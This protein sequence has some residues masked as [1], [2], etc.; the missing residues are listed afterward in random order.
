M[1][2]IV[3]ILIGLGVSVSALYGQKA[4]KTSVFLMGENEKNYESLKESYRHSLLE[5]C[6][7][8]MKK[9]FENW[10]NFVT[11]LEDYA[12]QEGVDINGVKL[13]LHTFFSPEG[14]VDHIGFLLKPTSKNVDLKELK[15]LL[16][17]FAKN[18]T[19]PIKYDHKF[20]HYT[21][22]TFPTFSQPSNRD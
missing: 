5:V 21:G 16:K 12:K 22:V 4:Q 11:T 17:E 20:Y 15:I 19:F 18:Y 3:C 6:D 2:A 14:N 10:I 1:K 13:W 8:D 7:S 9:A